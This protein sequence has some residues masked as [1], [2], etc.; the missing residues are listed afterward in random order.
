MAADGGFASRDNLRQAKERGI[1]DVSFSKRNGTPVLD[2]VKSSWVHKRLR[3]FR[4]IAQHRHAA[5][6]HSQAAVASCGRPS[7][8]LF[9]P[10]PCTDPSTQAH[11][12]EVPYQK[13]SPPESRETSSSRSICGG[14]CRRHRVFWNCAPPRA[15]RCSITLWHPHTFTP[16][17][18]GSS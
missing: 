2:M 9:H 16:L 10:P 13:N 18:S 5:Q 15:L 14:S 3:N 1:A 8:P 17:F 12:T 11:R 6:P 7:T 4:A